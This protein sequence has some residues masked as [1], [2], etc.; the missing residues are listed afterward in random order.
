MSRISV[1][2]CDYTGKIFKDITE[3]R[4][5]L[6][7][8]AKHNAKCGKR[9]RWVDEALAA[10]QGCRHIRDMPEVLSEVV[11]T[12][13]GHFEIQGEVTFE[14]D[15]RYNDHISNSH[16][17]PRDGVENWWGKDG[18]PTGYPG[19]SGKIQY[20]L[21][22]FYRSDIDKAAW[23][24]QCLDIHRLLRCLGIHTGTGSGSE[25]VYSYE[26]KLFESDFPN[27]LDKTERVIEGIIT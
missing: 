20:T 14:L 1:W 19:Y 4:W 21:S 9:K 10:V 7:N 16:Y 8:L 22:T 13:F 25:V 18:L 6:R 17:C 23:D 15:I 26:V 5:Y 12:Y 3:Y 11:G 2:E 27:L 24:H